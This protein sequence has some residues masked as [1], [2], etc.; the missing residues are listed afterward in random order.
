MLRTAKILIPVLVAMAPAAA[1]AETWWLVAGEPGGRDAWFVD[2]D[3]VAIRGDAREFRL[4]HVT[5]AG[6]A[7]AAMSRVRCDMRQIEPSAVAVQKFVCADEQKR[8]SLGAMLGSLTPE[9]AAKAI[10]TAPG[11]DA[12]AMVRSD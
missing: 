6:S 1:S 7:P 11:A 9:L 4:M 2:S 8:M 5:R 10:F 12:Q 3:S